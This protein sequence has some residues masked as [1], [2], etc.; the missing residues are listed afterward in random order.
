MNKRFSFIDVPL[1]WVEAVGPDDPMV[2]KLS[3]V[4]KSDRGDAMT[5]SHLR[6]VKEFLESDAKYGIICED[7]IYVR[8]SFKKDIE[9]AIAAFER[10]K[11]S[12]L[13]LGYLT[14]YYPIKY[15]VP[16][17]FMEEPFVYFRVYKDLWGAQMYMINKSTAKLILERFSDFEKIKEFS[18]D[19]TITKIEN[20]AFMYPMLAVE[21]VY[22]KPDD[23]PYDGQ[24][25]FHK[26]SEEL[27]Y[28][29]KNYI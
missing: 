5:L 22:P 21:K 15:A 16:Q 18:P 20:G 7:D 8:R 25:I 28:N 12:I 11:V 19:W 26:R 14:S 1:N 29:P 3:S 13:L 6:A 9:V 23:N 24:L 17:I 10:L 4:R 27:H 2:K